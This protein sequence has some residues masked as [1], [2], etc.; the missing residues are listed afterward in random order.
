MRKTESKTTLTYNVRLVASEEVTNY[1]LCLLGEAAKAYDACAK[2]VR[3]ND[4]TLN[5]VA[6]HHACYDW[7]RQQYSVLSG[8]LHNHVGLTENFDQSENEEFLV[9][10]SP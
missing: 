9:N 1:W 7:M 2:F 4:V 6:I 5:T 8:H 3:K 10:D